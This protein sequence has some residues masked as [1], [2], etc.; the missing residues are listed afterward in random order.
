M[1]EAGHRVHGLSD[2]VLKGK[3]KFAEKADAVLEFIADSPL[4][5]HNAEFDVGFLNA[6]LK[7]TGRPALAN[8]VC[9][10][11]DY[12]RRTF[13]GARATLDALCTRFKVDRSSRTVHGA[14]LDASLLAQLYA[15]M[16]GIDGLGISGPVVGG[17]V[18]SRGD[19][20]SNRLTHSH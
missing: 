12:A 13:P 3:P 15:R 5:I 19:R 10:T 20:T 2:E 9:D 6:E 4:V 8:E 16:M 14:L 18:A 17:G 7:A 1:P 11:L